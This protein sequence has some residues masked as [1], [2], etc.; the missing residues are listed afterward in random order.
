MNFNLICSC[1]SKSHA[2]SPP[3]RHSSPVDRFQ[4]YLLAGQVIVMG[5][6]DLIVSV[7]R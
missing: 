1:Q 7:A 6:D 4:S 2:A 5:P 3:E